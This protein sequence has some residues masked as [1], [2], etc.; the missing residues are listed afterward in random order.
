M[1]EATPILFTIPNFT[2]AGSGRAMLNIVERLDRSRFAPTICTLKPGGSLE[3]E[4]ERLG[5]PY[6]HAAFALPARP[7]ATLAMRAHRA[8]AAFRPHGFVLWH[9]FHYLDDY[10]EPLVAR[11][12]GAKAWIYTKKNMNW[13]RRS[14]WLRSLLASRVAAQNTDMV[15][16]F[17][18]SPRLRRK[19]V[20]VPRGVD[21]DRFRPDVPRR[22]GLREKLGVPPGAVVAGCVAQILPVKGHP[23]LI[24]A[25]ARVPELRLWLAGKELDE[26]YAAGLREQIRSLGLKDRVT[27]LGEV[28]DVPAF[29]AELD[30]FVLPTWNEWRMEGCPVSL[31][32]AMSSAR[33]C[34]ATDIPGSRDIVESGR[35][36]VLVRPQDAAALAA[37]LGRLLGDPAQRR[38]LGDAARDR[39]RAGYAIE[40]EVKA[41]EDLYAG[42]LNASIARRAA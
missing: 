27:F 3:A 10:T 35:S 8:A 12:A 21:T 40:V 32:E 7:L 17:F 33:P 42:V 18:S 15:R 4:I 11:F 22:L 24:E 9:S 16:D 2:T 14:W 41:H 34:I 19:T 6:I 38:A 29:L 20:L 13:N 1:T 39:I 5:I 26:N 28:Q 23:T 30:L 31:L 25:L 36:G 37:A